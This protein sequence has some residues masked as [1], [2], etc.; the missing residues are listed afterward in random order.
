MNKIFF[1]LLLFLAFAAYGQQQKRVA[2][3]NTVDD[4]NP[5]IEPLELNQLTNRLRGIAT[6]VLPTSN[7]AIMTQQSIVA[8][9]GTQEEAAR[10]CRESEC[11]AQLGSSGKSLLCSWCQRLF[12]YKPVYME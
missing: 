3:I 6:E 7:Y 10:K 1:M 5:P 9:L 4:G 2:I 12:L 11:L 8:F